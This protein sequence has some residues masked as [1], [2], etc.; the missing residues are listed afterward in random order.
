[1]YR[2]LACG[3]CVK[4]FSKKV[5]LWRKYKFSQ[6]LQPGNF[7]LPIL[8]FI[9]KN[10]RIFS[11]ASSEM[12]QNASNSTQLSEKAIFKFYHIRSNSSISFDKNVRIYRIC[13][14]NTDVFSFQVMSACESCRICSASVE[15]V[16]GVEGVRMKTYLCL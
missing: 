7:I 9:D 16:E 13:S 12:L 2:I 4:N 10:D 1:M 5:T 15:S 8:N 11:N 14:I 3:R 6:C